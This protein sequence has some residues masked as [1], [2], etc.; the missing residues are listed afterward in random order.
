[1]PELPEVET[2]ARGLAKHL[3]GRRIAWAALTRSDMVH[4]E[5]VPLCAAVLG[6]RIGR[7]FRQGKQVRMDLGAGRLLVFHL[8]M[9]GRL[10][11]ADRESEVEPHTHLRITFE[12]WRRELRFSDPRRFGGIWLT[13]GGA[14]GQREWFGRRLPPTA[15]DPLTISLE[16]FR[17][18]LRRRRQIK[19]LL[20]DQRPISGVGNIYCDEAL[21]RACIH[22]R[23]RADELDTTAVGKL[24]RCLR[25]VLTEAVRAGGS[26]ISDYRTSDNQP[27]L[28][29]VKH[30][31]YGRTGHPCPRCGVRI[32]HLVV[33]GRST[34][35]CPRCQRPC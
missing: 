9:T 30:R 10:I 13:D 14:S 7:V 1:M 24:W 28:F 17:R 3:T 2:I 33:A 15:E 6:R 31:V 29:Q 22:P 20:L 16:D 25:R 5:A 18:A 34:F 27:G 21:H 8:G 23:M 12:R 26:S 19:A 32:T 4:G 11:V 35:I